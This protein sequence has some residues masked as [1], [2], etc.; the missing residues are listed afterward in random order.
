MN[1]ARNTASVGTHLDLPMTTIFTVK[2][3]TTKAIAH[4]LDFDLIATAESKS[5]ALKKLRA[6]VKHHIEFGF[7][8]GLSE[9][10]IQRKAPQD[11]WDKIKHSTFTLGEDIEIDNHLRIVT[12]MVIDE[13]QPSAVPAC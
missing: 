3:T 2:E 6:A 10:E 11:C 7:K 8:H 4:A 5:E 1:S 9:N 13:T 12:R